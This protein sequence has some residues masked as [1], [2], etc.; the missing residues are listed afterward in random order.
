MGV[1]LANSG[2]FRLQQEATYDRPF[3]R[4]KT[5]WLLLVL[6]RL[7]YKIGLRLGLELLGLTLDAFGIDPPKNAD[8]KEFF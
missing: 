4:P 5:V 2:S 1:S 3:I 6:I 7:S 8:A